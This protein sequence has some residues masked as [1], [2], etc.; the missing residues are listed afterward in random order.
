MPAGARRARSRASRNGTADVPPHKGVVVKSIGPT[1][2]SHS[3]SVTRRG[4]ALIVLAGAQF[5]VTL[6]TSI[7]NVALPAVRDGVGLSDSGMSWV[8]NAYGLAFGA[9]LLSGGRAGD[10][11]GRRR[12]LLAGLALFAAASI[13][14]GLA[15]TAWLLIGARTAQGIGAAAVAPAA[16]ALVM[17]LFPPGPGRGR[18]LGVWGAVS[19]AGGAAGVLAGGLLTE[20]LGWPWIFHVS[21]FGAACVC[22]AA[23][24]LLPATAPPAPAA[25]RLDLA[26]T[27][28]VTLGLVALVHGLTA[29]R[30]SGWTDPLVLTSL[31][32]ATL[33]LLLFVVVERHHPASLIP[34]QLLTTGTVAPA[35]LVMTLL[36]AVWVGLFFFLPL[37]QQQVLGAGPLEAGLSQ[38][39]LAAANMLGSSLAPRLAGRL[40]AHVTL[41]AALLTQAS[42][43]LW[44][45]RVSAQGSFLADV[46]GPTL[47]IGLGLGVA[48]VQLTSAAVTGVDPADA[49][50]AGGLV[51]TTRQIGG[52]IG[53]A[54]LGTLAASTT[55]G[56]APHL[57]RTEAL[58]EGY[59]AAFLVSAGLIAA[60]AVLTPLLAR[61]AARSATPAQEPAASHSTTPHSPATTRSTR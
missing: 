19:G 36:G 17:Q 45:S 37:Y 16:L 12:V 58:T 27:L 8:V 40:G 29:A 32:A 5:V 50:L 9:L 61:R 23:A 24:T 34:P 42:G 57:S 21:G 55:A 44:L 46:L 1:R 28:A 31:T 39:P 22:A 51:N 53:L 13:T 52:A 20:S 18:A 49:G 35:N 7:V 56:A 15:S 60:G 54:L 4:A 3:L 38:L 10:L 14:A 48:F 30:R 47:V 26:G 33:L 41:A 11:L 43:L 25:R 6:S 2:S 59:R